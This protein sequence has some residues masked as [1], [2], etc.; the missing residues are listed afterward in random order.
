MIETEYVFPY[1]AHATMEPFNVTVQ[2]KGDSAEFWLGSQF[3]TVD[4]GVAATILNLPPEK[5]TINTLWAGGSFGRRAVPGSPFIAEAIA[6]A[7][8]ANTDQPVK[9]MWSREDDMRG[10]WYRPAYV[11]KVRAG[12]KAGEISGWSHRIVGQSILAGT[13][14]EAF[15]VKDGIDGTS[16]E[17]VS[18]HAYGIADFQAELH[19]T[20]TGVPPLWWRSVGHTHTAYAMETMM[21]QLAAAAGEDPVAFRR[22]LLADGDRRIGVLEKVAEMSNWSGPKAGDGRFRGVALHKSFSTYVAEI[23]EISIADDGALK[24]EDVWCAVDCGIAVNPDNVRAQIEGGV[25]YGLGAV[26]RNAITMT[27]GE[28][29]QG[30]FDSYE[31]LR[32]TDMPRIHVEIVASDEAPTG[33]GEPGTPPIGPAVANAIFAATGDTPACRLAIRVSSDARLPTAKRLK[34][35]THRRGA[36]PDAFGLRRPYFRRQFRR[37][38]RACGKPQIAAQL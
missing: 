13:P 21:E 6:V 37:L 30:N 15:L 8:A 32:I 23:A 3:Q 36:S 18:D 10:G 33:I 4:Q 25:G 17:G 20:T 38:R 24:V 31:P 5:V 22:Q 26:L 2:L 35:G 29:D 12:L 27:G 19:T 7:Q 34:R 1:L 11:H 14:F 16:V 9:L 28:V